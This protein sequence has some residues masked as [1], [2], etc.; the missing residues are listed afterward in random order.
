VKDLNCWC[1][2]GRL[3][4][5]PD[6]KYTPSG[7][8]V[9]NVRLAVNRTKDKPAVFL[10]LQVWRGAAEFAA[11]Y[12]A[13]GAQ[14]SIQGEIEVRDWTAQDGTKRTTTEIVVRE[15]NALGKTVTNEER[16]ADAPA[17]DV[18]EP[19]ADFADPFADE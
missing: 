11:K 19:A 7:V 4:A 16:P 5:D 14:V 15:L 9:A 17:P 10:T 1:G 8:A 6:L 2:T 18:N 3:C 13:K 12:L